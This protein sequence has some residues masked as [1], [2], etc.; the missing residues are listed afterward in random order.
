MET[1]ETEILSVT[2]LV[3][4]VGFRPF[5]WRLAQRLG[6]SGTVRNCGNAVEIVVCGPLDKRDALAEALRVEAPP[7]ARVEGVTR[8]QGSPSNY[9]DFSIA[10]SGPG[11]VTAGIVPDLATCPACCAEIFDPGARRYHYAF[12]N[13]TDCGPRFSILSGLPYDRA[14]TTMASFSLCLACR[15]DYENPAD[16]RFHAE[17][18]AC[19]DCG[20][21]LHF[22]GGDGQDYVGNQAF[23]VALALL[24]CGGILALKGIGGYHLACD[25]T[26]EDSVQLLRARKH[27]PTKPLAVMMRDLATAARYCALT[28]EERQALVD[29]SA[30]IVLVNRQDDSSLAPSLAPSLS[31]G[32]DRLGVLL[33]YTPL[34]HLLL[35][36]LA[37]PLVMS[38]G[39]RSG[40][41]QVFEDDVALRDLAEIADGWLMHDRPIARRL[42][43]SVVMVSAGAK[44]VLRRGRGLAPE[45]FLLAED[46]LKAPPILALGADLKS[47]FCLIQGG[48]ALLSHHLGD[49]NDPDSAATMDAAIT[50]YSALFTHRL[51]AIAIDLHPD[52]RSADLGRRLAHDRSLPLIAVQHHHAHVAAVMADHGLP[53]SAGPVIG[54]V[55][56]GLGFG[57]DGTIWGAEILLCDYARS[58]RLARLRP[59]PMPGSD[60]ASLEPWRNLLAS[61]DAAFGP[62][63][64][65]SRLHAAGRGPVLADRKISALRAMIK[66][67]FNAPLASSAGRLFDAMAA[68][69][70]VAPEIQTFEAEA[71][72]TL[73]ALAR[74]ASG[75]ASNLPFLVTEVDGLK[76]IDP[77]PMWAAALHRLGAGEAPLMIAAGFHAGLAAIFAQVAVD[78]A[79]RQGIGQIVLAGGVMQNA[80][81]FEALTAHVRAAGLGVLA[82][83]RAPANDGGLALG[84]AVIASIRLMEAD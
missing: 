64:S 2:G 38:S 12:T 7:R 39:N 56:D 29:P 15:A 37:F 77:E 67:G 44:R 13:C 5:V 50:D 8:I 63:E 62:Q 47:A 54:I 33:P 69:L 41:P 68:L 66:A 59:A 42:D 83:L 48:R 49:F 60:R 10:P 79:R 6:L 16:R 40:A 78:E 14:H 3:Q 27:R 4:G 58:R 71:A 22:V 17:P 53:R 36:A 9:M 20:P 81:L 72:M 82:P 11:E 46:F 84:Q 61:L 74:Q 23:E 26:R 30:P 28:Q 1:I 25:A 73:E 31:P 43:D 76:E 32:L 52:Y 21:R 70:G 35:D 45:P 19:P 55:L 34:H 18:I 24:R 80:L 57:D 51:A 65:M 75:E